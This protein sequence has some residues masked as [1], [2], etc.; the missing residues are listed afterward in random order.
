MKKNIFPLNSFFIF[1]LLIISLY[2]I[3]PQY[4]T[5]LINNKLPNIGTDMNYLTD[6]IHSSSS[7]EPILE[8][9]YEYEISLLVRNNGSQQIIG[10]YFSILP[11]YI[12]I[13]EEE[14]IFIEKK[15]SITESL[16]TVTLKWEK[17]INDFS[18][19]F[20]NLSNITYINF[21]KFNMEHLINASYMFYNNVDLK[22]I[23]FGNNSTSS[24]INMSYMFYN[25]YSLL[26]LNFSNFDITNVINMEYMLYNCTNI[27]SI[28]LTSFSNSNVENMSYMLYYC[29]VLIYLIFIH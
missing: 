7:I 4:T 2:Y 5:E 25:C 24:L 6:M 28:D 17:K 9:Y 1:N 22:Y 26:S 12:S 3:H 15:I 18:Y 20:S 14:Y 10:D 27:I 21:T 19:M 11:D 8:K 16:S 13:N 29:A 23:A